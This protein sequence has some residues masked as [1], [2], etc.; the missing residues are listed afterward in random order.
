MTD[1]KTRLLPLSSLPCAVLACVS[2]A[3]RFS[4]SAPPCARTRVGWRLWRLRRRFSSR[5]LFSRVLAPRLLLDLA[6]RPRLALGEP[7]VPRV[8]VRGHAIVLGDVGR[9]A[10]GVDAHEPDTAAQQTPPNGAPRVFARRLEGAR[11]DQSR[12][13]ARRAPL[14]VL[15]GD[16]LQDARVLDG[17][18]RRLLLGRRAHAAHRGPHIPL[19]GRDRERKA[20][21]LFPV[22]GTRLGCARRADAEPVGARRARDG[23]GGTGD[24]SAR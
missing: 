2:R 6:E 19:G 17:L 10:H 11:L 23:R 4:T 7:D 1:D 20:P 21:R 18:A 16:A 12:A 15:H 8:V 14:V 22:Q 3:S 9:D 24:A 5:R 13:A